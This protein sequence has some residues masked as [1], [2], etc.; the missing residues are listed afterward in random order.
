MIVLGV[1]GL[2]AQWLP[3]KTNRLV[4]DYSGILSESQRIGLEQRLVA[5]NDST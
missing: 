1:G 2:H 3:E 5:F 4:N